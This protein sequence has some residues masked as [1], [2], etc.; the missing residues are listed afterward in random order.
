MRIKTVWAVF[1][2]PTGNTAAAVCDVARTAA[3]T[4]HVPLRT[5]D[6]TLPAQRA[7]VH[8]FCETDFVVFGVPVYAGR[9]PNKVLPFL[10]AGFCGG[11]ALAVPVVT[12][13][14]RS[15]DDALIEL[16]NTL[17]E[18]GFH[19]VAGAAFAAG[20][21]FSE[22]IA[23]GHPT[24]ADRAQ[25]RAFARAA[26][27]KA[28]QAQTLP[29][30]VSVAGRDPVGPYYTPLGL[31]GKPAAFLKAKPKTHAE[32]CRSCG[33]C[34]AACPM[35]SISKDD[36]TA[37]P[38]LCIKCQACVRVCP[39]H[40]KYFDDPAFLSHVAMLEQTYTRPAQSQTFL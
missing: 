13:G 27:E 24:E 22:K 12:F 23:P 31:D 30:P 2:S 35:G 15:F 28:R 25:R 17:E 9:V 32:R 1:F 33:R 6:F 21:A 18:L 11:E 4:L 10:R 16:R 3:E 7:G 8:S 14:N 36:P 29:A 39:V 26:A 20:H 37:V 38:G 40:A 19:T 34:A 5:L